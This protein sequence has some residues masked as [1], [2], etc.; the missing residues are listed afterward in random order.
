LQIDRRARGAWG[1]SVLFCVRTLEQE[2]QSNEFTLQDFYRRFTS[3]LASR[4]PN[5]NNVQ[6]KLRQQL[7]VLRDGGVL[8]FL[9]HGRYKVIA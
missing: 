1:A 8:E 5:N 3:E 7:Q 4:Y 2:T 6:A 9:G